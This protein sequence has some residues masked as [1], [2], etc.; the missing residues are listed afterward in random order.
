MYENIYALKQVCK[1]FAA[2]IKEQKEL[3]R[4]LYIE[5]KIFDGNRVRNSIN[6]MKR[7]Y[8]R[9]HIAHC[10]LRGKVYEQVEQPK[11]QNK[12]TDYE[13]QMIEQIR[14]KYAIEETVHISA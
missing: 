1:S 11:E 7:N 3:A 6:G 8:R 12:I 4:K 2:N 13:W 5:G 14:S 9:H 10:L